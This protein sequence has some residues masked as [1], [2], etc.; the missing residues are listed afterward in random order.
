MLV[1]QGAHAAKMNSVRYL[2]ISE[3]EGAPIIDFLLN[4]EPES[5]CLPMCVIQ[6]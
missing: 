6:N 5:I 1:F 3:D 4:R 2:N